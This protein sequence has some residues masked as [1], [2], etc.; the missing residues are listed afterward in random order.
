LTPRISIIRRIIEAGIDAHYL[1][2]TGRGHGH[3][4]GLTCRN[5]STRGGGPG[6]TIIDG[7]KD[8]NFVRRIRRNGGLVLTGTGHGDTG[9]TICGNSHR[10]PRR[11]VIN[12]I[13]N[14]RGIS[15]RDILT[16][17]GHG[18]KTTNI[19]GLLSPGD[20]I[21]QRDVGPRGGTDDLVETR[22]RHSNGGTDEGRIRNLS[23]LTS[24][25]KR[26]GNEYSTG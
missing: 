4:I 22:S 7:K 5:G 21:I 3:T 19:G 18:T 26:T 24:I 10:G 13:I 8:G 12:A 14:G 2:L 16:G 15:D 17:G 6:H 23:P 1:I 25:I 20:T 11:T 9:K